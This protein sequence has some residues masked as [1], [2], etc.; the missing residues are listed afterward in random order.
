MSVSVVTEEYEYDFS[1]LNPLYYFACGQD[2]N[3]NSLL[4][5]RES[6]QMGPPV[7]VPI[8]RTA[9]FVDRPCKVC[10]DIK[11]IPACHSD[12]TQFLY[13]HVRTCIFKLYCSEKVKLLQS[14]QEYRVLHFL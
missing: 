8:G 1:H 7:S 13:I 2:Q 5:K 3:Q 10:S 9:H 12:Q 4:V 11:L 6:L 14:V